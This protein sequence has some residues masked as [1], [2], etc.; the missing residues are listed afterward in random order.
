MNSL[1]IVSRKEAKARG[2]T[3]YFTGMPCKHGHVAERYV[4]NTHCIDCALGRYAANPEKGR[5]AS[6]AWGAANLEKKRAIFRAWAAA[7]PERERERKAAYYAANREKVREKNLARYSANP[8]KARAA[9]RS[10][11]TANPEKVRAAR[12]AAYAANPE[13]ERANTA[14]WKSANPEKARAYQRNRRSLQRGADGHHTAADVERILIAQKYK[15]ANPACR[16]P[17]KRNRHVDHIVPLSKGGSN[18]P[19]NLQILCPTCNI[20]KNDKHPIEFARGQGM[21]L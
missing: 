18:W 12:L 16:K 19:R 7:N 3:R 11:Y 4:G 20:R 1:L 6:A 13:R 14:K 10:Y 9:S 8:E 21:L 17:V 2:L 5:A 15:C